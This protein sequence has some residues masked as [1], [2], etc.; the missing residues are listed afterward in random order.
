M[1]QIFAQIR[2][3]LSSNDAIR[4]A[5][6]LLAA[7]QHAAGGRDISSVSRAACEEIIGSPSSAVC[8]KLAFDLIRSTRLTADQWETVCRGIK[9]DFDFPDPDVTAAAVSFL[10]A[11][12]NWRVGNLIMDLSKEIT[13]CISSD[14]E[15]LRSAIVE[16][17]GCLLARDD[18]VALCE[19]SGQLLDKASAWWSTIGQRMLDPSDVVSRFAF[20]GVARLFSEFSS[21]RMSR[22]AG[23]KL[24]PSEASLAIRSNWM[25]AMCRFAWEKRD[26]LMSRSLILPVESFRATV[27]PLVFAVK[28]VATNLVEAL[29][30]GTGSA[31][32]EFFNAERIL[33]VSDV[34]SHLVPFLSSLDPALVYEVTINL[35]SLA[36]VPGGKP[37]WASAPIT[38]LLTLW[39]RQD[40]NAGRESIVRAAVKNLQL[41]DLHMQVTLFKRL[42]LMVRNLRVEADRMH[43]LACICRTALSVDLFAKESVRRGQKALPGTDIASLFEEPK[44]KEDLLSVTSPSLFKEELVACLVESCFQLSLPLMKA[45]TSGSESRVLGALAYGTGY[46]TYSW[47]Q[48]ALEVVEVCRPCVKWDCDGRTYAMDCYLKLLVRLCHIYDT[49]GGVKKAKDGASPEQILNETRL[50]ILQRQL[51]RDLSEVGTP[52]LRARL[53]WALTE[54]FDLD[55]LD[56]LLADDP[57]DPL[58]IIIANMHKV[59]FNSDAPLGAAANRLQDV[60]AILLCAQHLGSRYPRAAQSLTKELEDFRNSNLADSVNKHQCR[61]V[62]QI[63]KHIAKH[64]E[65][66]WTGTA[67]ATGD[68]PFSHHKLSVQYY[69]VSAAQDR[70]LEDLVHTAVQELWKPAPNPLIATKDSHASLL[71]TPPI[72]RTLSGSSDP[73]YVEAYHLTDPL[74]RR[75]T[76]HLKVINMTDLELNRVDV[77]V[78]LVGS[79]HF[80]DGHPQAVRQL[81]HLLSQDPTQC[82]VT[83]GV[84]R[85]ERCALCVQLLYYPFFGVAAGSGDEVDFGDEE[86]LGGVR[87]RRS[88][89][90]EYGEPIVLRCRSYKI[91]LIELLL[92][93]ECSPVE[94]F[95]LWPSLPAIFEHTGAYM[96]EGGGLK[97]GAAAKLNFLDGF[98]SLASKP[99]H[100]VCSHILRSVAGF[101]LCY[102]AKTWYGDFLGMLIFGASEVSGNVDLGDETHTMVCKFVLRS[103]SASLL[104]EIATDLQDWLDDLTDGTIDVVPEEAVQAAAAE[105]LRR[106]ME[107]LA[108]PKVTLPP[109]TLP[110]V[111]KEDDNLIQ[112]V[113]ASSEPST[114]TAFLP[115]E[116]EHKALQ[117]AVLQEWEIFRS[118]PT[119]F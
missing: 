47:T 51:A 109:V 21:K 89:K 76:L 32:Q 55:G 116:I 59:L 57:E 100:K 48:S 102:A 61:L 72:A 62:L 23:D 64:P 44:I 65:S 70:K 111:K 98:K 15:N 9:N 45:K 87:H 67:A 88:G 63:F 78:G 53:I 84:S 52:R 25:T 93:H 103:S 35:L 85:F 19:T 71:K 86:T 2:L 50:Q 42:L 92:P 26:L 5:Q 99:F 80:M 28:A 119:I 66:R 68:Y 115:E 105:K 90:P 104:D 10:A 34:V 94:F 110:P 81:Q 33:G 77:R 7:L 107:L 79:L 22:L 43:A 3:D 37:E 106:S 82:S 8:K 54:H 108:L 16:T 11:V 69:D 36:D 31:S 58:N 97:A 56:P 113:Q 27:F 24:V 20:E 4:Q 91:P 112:G 39:D 12:P 17:L 13:N 18:F 30:A 29:P 95:R 83:V 41:L 73:C 75:L 14:N 46:E 1:D 117:A 38:A 114:L 60:Q 49:I 96:Y 101:Q 118:E 40:F 74:E 6:A